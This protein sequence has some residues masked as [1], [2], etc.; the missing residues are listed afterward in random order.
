MSDP[1]RLTY[2]SSRMTL[3]ACVVQI[4]AIAR[5]AVHGER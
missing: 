4:G 3:H 5:G 2:A 1:I